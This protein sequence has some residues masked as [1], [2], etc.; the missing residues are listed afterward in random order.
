VFNHQI[1]TDLNDYKGTMQAHTYE[2]PAPIFKPSNVIRS[3]QE[4]GVR[5]EWQVRG[6]LVEWLDGEFY[7]HVVLE[8]I[9]PGPEYDKRGVPVPTLSVPVVLDN[10]E[11]TRNY[12]TEIEFSP[13]EIEVGVYK[14]A[15][16][17][18]LYGCS[19]N[20]TPIAGFVEGK[21]VNIFNP[22]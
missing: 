6:P 20:P 2:G 22:K 3:D 10:G 17:L 18:Q 5:I 11:K 9:G 15:T 12:Y 14:I 8:S 21:M 13:G 16:T 7:L 4:W 19:D 1:E